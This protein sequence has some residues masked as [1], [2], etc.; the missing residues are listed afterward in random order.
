[1]LPRSAVA[2]RAVSILPQRGPTVIG[3]SENHT[4]SGFRRSTRRSEPG[5]PSSE[6]SPIILQAVI[7]LVFI[8]FFGAILLALQLG[9][10][11]GTRRAERDP[12]H[13]AEGFGPSTGPCTGSWD[14]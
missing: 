11:A 12:E 7:V 1:V 8:V 13:A 9:R 10:R 4:A 14:F 2:A 5:L 6:G 3:A